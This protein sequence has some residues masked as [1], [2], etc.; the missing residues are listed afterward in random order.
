[1][2]LDRRCW[3]VVE[4][5]P[6]QSRKELFVVLLDGPGA[7]RGRRGPT[8]TRPQPR[9][10]RTG[11]GKTPTSEGRHGNLRID[12]RVVIYRFGGSRGRARSVARPVAGFLFC[13][14]NRR[15]DHP[16]ATTLRGLPP[17][18]SRRTGGAPTGGLAV[19]CFAA[20]AT[21]LG[22]QR[23]AP[24]G[25]ALSPPAVDGSAADRHVSFRPST[26]LCGSFSAP[27]TD[28]AVPVLRRWARCA[29]H[30]GAAG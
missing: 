1:M 4:P 5:V 17:E 2:A 12:G 6:G 9:Y 7:R 24:A 25:W 8:S 11:G 20:S 30:A 19:G 13:T 15:E 22:S 3:A 27:G 16:L 10:R 26:R 21:G 14:S 23:H 28:P 18:P 29:G